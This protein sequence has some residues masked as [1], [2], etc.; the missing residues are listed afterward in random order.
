MKMSCH[1]PI[2]F[3]ILAAGGCSTALLSP[4][5]AETKQKIAQAERFARRGDYQAA[6][7]EYE[8]TLQVPSRNPWQ[9]QVLFRLGGL[10]AAADNPDQ[11]FTRSLSCF[12]RLSDD[13]PKSRFNAQSGVWLGLLEKLVS[14]ESEIEA[15][16]AELAKN[17]LLADREFARIEA[18]RLEREASRSAEISLQTK[19]LKELE[20]L[21]ESQKA[22]LESLQR[23]LKKMKEIDIQSEK[24][25]K[26]IK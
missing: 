23:Q 12:Q 6:I 13:F 14:L 25:A 11:D 18:E 1:L 8:Q 2:V 26:G 21:V 4:R 3:A 24:K 16:Q 17:K 7:A 19:K 20:I 5:K 9:D 15:G 22:A 10:H